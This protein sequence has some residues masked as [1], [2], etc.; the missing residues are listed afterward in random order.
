MESD[1]VKKCISIFCAPQLPEEKRHVRGKSQA[2]HPTPSWRL[3]MC[4]NRAR[5]SETVLSVN[6]AQ[7]LLVH[8]D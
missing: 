5:L 1:L 8:L 4:M 6:G 3:Y 7:Q 2:V